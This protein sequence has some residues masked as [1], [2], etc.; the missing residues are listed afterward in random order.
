MLTKN[1]TPFLHGTKVTSLRPPAPMMSIYP[2]I[3][4]RFG[5]ARLTAAALFIA[6][7]LSP[8]SISVLILA[9]GSGGLLSLD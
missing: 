4:A 1:L 2:I 6:T 5:D 3:G 9:L 7:V 8:V